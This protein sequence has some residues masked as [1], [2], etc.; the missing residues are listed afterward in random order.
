LDEGLGAHKVNK[1]IAAQETKIDRKLIFVSPVRNSRDEIGLT[2][3]PGRPCHS[4]RSNPP[5]HVKPFIHQ[6]CQDRHF[7]KPGRSNDTAEAGDFVGQTHQTDIPLSR[8]G[9]YEQCD[10]PYDAIYT[11]GALNPLPQK[12]L[13]AEVLCEF[14][15]QYR[16]FILPKSIFQASPQ[17]SL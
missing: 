2:G 17:L 6:D 1:Y 4:R 11:G 3:W 16:L 14:S 15:Q 10:T 9:A 13:C 8:I 12:H 7:P 5:N